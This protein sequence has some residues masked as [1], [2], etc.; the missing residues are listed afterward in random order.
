MTAPVDYTADMETALRFIAEQPMQ[1]ERDLEGSPTDYKDDF[2]EKAMEMVNM[3]I[4]VARK[5]LHKERVPF[6]IP[7]R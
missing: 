4:D 3:L 2:G 1:G 6:Q 5:T 7:R